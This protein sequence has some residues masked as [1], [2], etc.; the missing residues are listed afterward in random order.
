MQNNSRGD[1]RFYLSFYLRVFEEKKFIGF[2]VDISDS[3]FK[4]LS[5]FPHSVEKE[6]KIRMKLPQ[7]IF[8]GDNPNELFVNFNALC[9]WTVRDENDKDFHLNGFKFIDIEEDAKKR[10]GELIKQFRV[11][12]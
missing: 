7:K 11:Y 2:L 9:R 5:E 8:N 10:I 1:E 4:V 3:G 6:Y 12:D